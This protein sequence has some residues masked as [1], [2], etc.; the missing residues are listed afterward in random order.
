MPDLTDL[1]VMEIYHAPGRTRVL[2]RKYGQTTTII[3]RI[4]GG[5]GPFKALI[6]RY[7]NEEYKRLMRR[8]YGIIHTRE[9]KQAQDIRAN[10]PDGKF[11]ESA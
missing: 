9:V 6:Q 8:Q 3:A 2:A 4:K 11:K 5:A 7:K 1:Q 10:N